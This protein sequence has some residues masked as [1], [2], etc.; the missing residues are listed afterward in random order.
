MLKPFALAL[1]L[2][3]PALAATWGETVPDT[4]A[5]LEILPGWRDGDTHVAAMRLTLA[6][7]WKTY[8][9]SPG[10]AGL[11]P[12]F[13]WSGS[14]NLGGVRFE[15][16]VP[17]V[18]HTN[19][20][21]SIG[22]HDQLVL[23]MLVAVGTQGQPVRLRGELQVGVCDTVCVPWSARFDAVLPAGG[24]PDPAIRAALDD[25]AQTG[26]E[27][28][29]GP[30]RCAAEPI[31]DGL[32]LTATIDLPRQ[33]R[34]EVVV[35]ETGTQGIWVSEATAERQSG[36]LV[37]SADLVPPEAQPFPVDRSALRF[38]VIGDGRA[39]DIRGCKGG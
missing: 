38:T 29:A 14:E 36:Q 34:D 12:V 15:W 22:Y 16:P 17:D 27:A 33:G 35:I 13:S 3:L 28:G 1:L 7:G 8:W 6:P 31:A 11:P 18:F 9:R 10:A 23:P 25:R 2:P 30:V 19:G 37:A 4:V 39:V 26:A 21:R 20:M 24:A 5:R 32:R